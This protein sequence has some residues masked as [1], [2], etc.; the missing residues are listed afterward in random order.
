EDPTTVHLTVRD[1]GNGF[2]HDAQSDGFGL[3][4]IRE[5]TE[6][7]D[8]ELQV[9]STPGKGTTLSVRLPVRR[10]TEDTTGT[11][12]RAGQFSATADA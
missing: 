10:R 9:N 3:L 7:L 4:G 12:T 8:G 6:L 2:D 5:R 11:H 1:D